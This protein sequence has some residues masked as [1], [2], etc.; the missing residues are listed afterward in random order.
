MLAMFDATTFRNIKNPTRLSNAKLFF[1]FYILDI[2][3]Q[4]LE[5]LISDGR[6]FAF[7]GVVEWCDGPG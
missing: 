3:L 1:Y 2:L 4:K 5:R 7:T 6:N